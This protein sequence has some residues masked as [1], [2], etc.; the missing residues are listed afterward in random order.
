MW[1]HFN[2]SVLG[3]QKGKRKGTVNIC[4]Q[5]SY[6][7]PIMSHFKKHLL[8]HSGKR[9]FTCEICC[10]SFRQKEHLKSHSIVHLTQKCTFCRMTFFDENEF[11]SHMKNVPLVDV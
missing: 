9:P 1:L 6:T 4:S 8:I 3:F 5:C 10:K 11:K 7:T 2:L